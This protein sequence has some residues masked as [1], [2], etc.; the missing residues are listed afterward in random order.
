MAAVKAETAD[1][2]RDR[3]LGDL[4]VL[5]PRPE[6]L[7]GELLERLAS[8]FEASCAFFFFGLSHRVRITRANN[9]GK[10][11]LNGPQ[12]YK[13]TGLRTARHLSRFMFHP[14]ASRITKRQNHSL[15]G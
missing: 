7:D 8:Q 4:G 14:C 3:G 2:Q 6:T 1:D 15:G 10:S 12:D 11:M 9:W 5:A 13:T